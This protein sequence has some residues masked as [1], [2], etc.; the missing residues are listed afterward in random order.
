MNDR[1]DDTP[2]PVIL[3]G[4]QHIQKFNRQSV[5]RVAVFMAI[6]RI[7]TKRIDLVLTMNVPVE[8]S[9]E[10]AVGEQGISAAQADFNAAATSLRIIDYGLFA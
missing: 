2:S 5:D 10:D 4:T 3:T 7:E 1:G 9:D 6:Y 8:A